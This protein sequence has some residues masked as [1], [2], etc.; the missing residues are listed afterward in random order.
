[1]RCRWDIHDSMESLRFFLSL[2]SCACPASSVVRP[3]VSSAQ[4][5]AA[6]PAVDVALEG[7]CPISRPRHSLLAA[8]SLPVAPGGRHRPLPGPPDLAP[9]PLEVHNLQLEFILQASHLPGGLAGQR[10]LSRLDVRRGERDADRREG[11]VP[12]EMRR[13]V[14]QG[15]NLRVRLRGAAWSDGVGSNLYTL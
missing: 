9:L 8:D 11:K 1:M 6:A 13:T 14:S 4:R 7:D 5:P 2:G 15:T 10:P 12:R 3:A